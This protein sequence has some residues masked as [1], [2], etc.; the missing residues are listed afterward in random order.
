MKKIFTFVFLVITLFVSA[1][2]L[3]SCGGSNLVIAIPN[4]PTNEARALLLLQ[5]LH[6]QDLQV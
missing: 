2:S 5:T 6:L 3:A 1:F 4:D